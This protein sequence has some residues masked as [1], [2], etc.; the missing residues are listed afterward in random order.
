[1][2]KAAMQLEDT[3]LVTQEDTAEAMVAATDTAKVI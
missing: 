1:V 2:V 3:E